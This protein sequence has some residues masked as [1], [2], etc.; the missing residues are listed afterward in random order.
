MA[1]IRF[2]DS[3]D[4][5]SAAV[6][7]IE[8]NVVRITADLEPNTN[9]FELFLRES[10]DYP[11]DNGE[12]LEYTT[13]YNTGD[14][15]FDLSNDGSVYAESGEDV[16]EQPTD[17]ELAEMERQNHIYSINLN[18][19][20]LK[21]MIRSTDYQITKTYE[22]SLVGKDAGYDIEVLHAQRQSI[23][24]QIN[25]LETQMTSLITTE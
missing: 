3:E 25:E 6:L 5:I 21:E 16:S 17:E 20:K 18:I 22:Y 9:G 4:F 23:R 11:L 1:Y 8:N 15:W 24:D 10:E 7:P 12:Y 19:E 14:G 13:L 2:K